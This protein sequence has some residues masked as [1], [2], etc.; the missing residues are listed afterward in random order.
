MAHDATA[1]SAGFALPTGTVTFV[2]TDIEGSTRA[3]ERSAVEMSAAVA[4]HYEILDRA[5]SAH[6]G[7]RPVEQG[8]GDSVVA[9]FSRASDAV[10]AAFDAQRA[11]ATEVWPTPGEVRVRMA[12]HTGEAQLRDERN[13]FGPVVI[14]CAANPRGGSWRPGVGVRCHGFARRWNAAGRGDARRSRC[15]PA[16]GPRSS[17][18]CVATGPRRA[19]SETSHRCVASIRTGRTCRSR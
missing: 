10:A 5:V 1:S 14:R 7:V 15:C 3:W 6:R 17:R 19:S 12:V 2:M 16:Q 9:A 11:L 4:R 8:E 13:Y 18:A